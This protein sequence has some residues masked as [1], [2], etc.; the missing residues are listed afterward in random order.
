MA[1]QNSVHSMLGSSPQRFF[2]VNK[3]HEERI[4]HIIYDG[5][6]PDSF[7]NA[8]LV[9]RAEVASNPYYKNY[10]ILKDSIGSWYKMGVVTKYYEERGAYSTCDLRYT[11]AGFQG[12]QP[13]IVY[14][15]YGPE[16]FG[17]NA[18]NS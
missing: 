10:S 13:V 5:N 12:G 7:E 15:S 11:Y 1:L 14:R 17:P 8:I 9:T 4:D 6:D 3:P 18:N 16:T 2:G